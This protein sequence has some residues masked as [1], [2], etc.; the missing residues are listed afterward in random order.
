MNLFRRAPN[1]HLLEIPTRPWLD[2]LSRT[3]GRRLT[4]A[5]VPDDV[6][7]DIARRGF[8]AVWLMGV[9]TTG[10]RARR[11]SLYYPDL[12]ASYERLQP[13]WTPGDVQGSPYSIGA[14]EVAPALG[15]RTA[16]ATLRRRLAERGLALM[17]D[18]VPNH[19]GIDHPWLDTNP[20][21]FV[22][23]TPRQLAAE[24][25]NWF[26]HVRDGRDDRI[27]AHGRDPNF[28]GWSDTVQVD[29]RHRAGREA[30]CAVVR[31][32][33]SQCD[34]LRCD[35]AMLVLSEVLERTWG[36]GRPDEAAEFWPEAI[37]AAR[38]VDPDFLFLAEV[39]WGLG[40]RLR[41]LGFD[42]VYEKDLTDALAGDDLGALDGY[43]ARSAEDL[44]GGAHFLENHDEKRAAALLEHR[45]AAAAVLAY[46]LPGLRFFYDGQ[47][48]GRREHVPVQL[49]RD[50]AETD[51]AETIEFYERL[52]AALA[53]DVWQHGTWSALPAPEG[54]GVRGCLWTT[55]TACALAIANYGDAEASTH[56][57]I[58]VTFPGAIRQTELLGGA[59]KEAPGGDLADG[60]H[61]RLDAWGAKL[62][63]WEAL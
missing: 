57:S 17:L 6:L 28:I 54:P 61:V 7:D 55:K 4:L 1:P 19:V 49:A 12:L 39:Y 51:A 21:V 26:V 43:F 16:L 48:E 30:M 47:R 8:H 3:A 60:V 52:H 10:E 59:T 34:A 56:V 13:D 32:L 5:D 44:A 15:D 9:W 27:Y 35:V 41:E 45:H 18:L 40:G 2:R 29:L 62:Y 36:P 20:D 25:T 24:P 33:A 22:P 63:R 38:E 37:R 53:G 31:D 23:G 11:L 14:Y 50:A 58:P 46:S 42:Y